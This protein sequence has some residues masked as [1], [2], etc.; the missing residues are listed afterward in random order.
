MK[1]NVYAKKSRAEYMYLIPELKKWLGVDCIVFFKKVKA[2][3]NDAWNEGGIPHCIH[4]LERMQIR[5][6]LRDMTNNEWSVYEYDNTWTD[7]IE[8][9][10]C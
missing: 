3:P 10:I 1:D 6:K 4:S 5:N 2:E 7:I 9:C 8:E